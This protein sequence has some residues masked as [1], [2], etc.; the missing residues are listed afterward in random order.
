MTTIRPIALMPMRHSSER[1]PGKNYRDFNGKPLF[2]RVLDEL[3]E[4]DE[5]CKIVI[6]SDSPVI[7]D[8]IAEHYPSV[9]HIDRPES[10][11]G[12]DMPMTS[13]LRY[14]AEQ[15]PNDWY[16]QTHSTNPLLTANTVRSAIQALEANLDQYDSLFSVT[17]L[18]TRLYD[19]SFQ[20][21][22]HDPNV[23]LRTQDL[24]PIYEE[25][26]NIYLYTADQIATG[27]RIGSAPMLFETDPLEAVDIDIETDFVLAETLHRLRNESQT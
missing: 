6:D 26:S 11:L 13:I 12:G 1:V 9:V 23:L 21:V 7:R 25:N 16:L 24:P 15:F 4:V 19:A 27:R 18:Q 20:P 5:I 14:D 17:R 3:L 2:H 22:N 8:Q 10:L